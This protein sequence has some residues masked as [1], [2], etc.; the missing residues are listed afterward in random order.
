MKHRHVPPFGVGKP[1]QRTRS[2]LGAPIGAREAGGKHR[3][4]IELRAGRDLALKLGAV[5]PLSIAHHRAMRD[6]GDLLVRNQDGAALFWSWQR[7]RGDTI[8]ATSS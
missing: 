5:R 3:A 8:V 6:A 1:N 4:M 2:D 7:S